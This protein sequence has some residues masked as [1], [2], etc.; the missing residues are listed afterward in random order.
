MHPQGVF[1]TCPECGNLYDMGSC[2][3]CGFPHKQPCTCGE[4]Y[5]VVRCDGCDKWV[6]YNCLDV[7]GSANFALI[8]KEC[9]KLPCAECHKTDDCA[10][11]YDPIN[12]DS[13][14]VMEK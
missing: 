12:K 9:A 7:K 5:Y 3:K 14:C 1:I 2:S 11:A 6:C 4:N 13:I 10:Y 8:C